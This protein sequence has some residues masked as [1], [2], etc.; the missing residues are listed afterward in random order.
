MIRLEPMNIRLPDSRIA[1]SVLTTKPRTVVV[2]HGPL[3]F[4]AYQRELMTSAPDNAQ[5]R[6]L[7][8]VARTP[9]S[10]AVAMANDAWAIRSVSVDLTVAPVPE[11]REMVE[12][13]PLNPDLVLSPGRYVLV[14]KN[15]AYDFVVAGKV[16]DRAHCLER[17]ET[18]DGD[19]F[20]ECR[21][22][23]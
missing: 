19:R 1:V 11:S 8:Q 12:L 4:V 18:P 20:T 5:L 21:N 23:P 14:F 9:S 15:Q 6:I 13:Q 10:P 7:A 17:A 16:T 22:L 2:P 3:S